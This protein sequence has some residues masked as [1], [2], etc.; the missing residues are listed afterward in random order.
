MIQFWAILECRKASMLCLLV[1]VATSNVRWCWNTISTSCECSSSTTISILHVYMMIV[2][3]VLKK[4]NTWLLFVMHTNVYRYIYTMCVPRYP[5]QLSGVTSGVN[6]F[7]FFGEGI[8]WFI[9]QTSK[10]IEPHHLTPTH[11][12][13]PFLGLLQ[14]KKKLSSIYI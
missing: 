12:L 1:P 6:S 8:K 11:T 4:K 2:C 10:G 5:L 13:D 9:F 14:K 3:F 7:I